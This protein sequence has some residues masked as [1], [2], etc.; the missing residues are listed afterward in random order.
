MT[1]P[2]CPGRWVFRLFPTGLESKHPGPDV[3]GPYN[4]NRQ[5]AGIKNRLLR[6]TEGAAGLSM[7]DPDA[8]GD[9]PRGDNRQNG[10]GDPYRHHEKILLSVPERPLRKVVLW[11]L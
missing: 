8:P 3:S 6:L 4:R 10:G 11:K 5:A 2:Y 1:L 7:G 9:K